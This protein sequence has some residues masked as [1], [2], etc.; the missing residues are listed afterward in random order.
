MEVT[1]LVI[2]VF[3]EELLNPKYVAVSVLVTG[4]N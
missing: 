1:A 3:M 4:R 2:G